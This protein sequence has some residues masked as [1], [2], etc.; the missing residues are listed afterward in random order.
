M[1]NKKE[2]AIKGGHNVGSNLCDFLF[3]HGI[4]R[5]LFTVLKDVFESAAS[6]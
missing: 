6:G 1:A 2:N 5:I 3:G 4:R